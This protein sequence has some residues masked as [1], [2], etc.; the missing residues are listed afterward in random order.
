MDKQT[1]ERL[2]KGEVE[3]V[4]QAHEYG[5][6]CATLAVS[7]AHLNNER[8]QV[9]TRLKKLLPHL[10]DDELQTS[11]TKS[12]ERINAIKAADPAEPVPTSDYFGLDVNAAQAEITDIKSRLENEQ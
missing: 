7:E 5:R 4:Q 8:M 6:T 2:I 12:I 1:V 11:V 9:V 3:R 10:K